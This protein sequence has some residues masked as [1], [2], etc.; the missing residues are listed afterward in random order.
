MDLCW[1][2]SQLLYF[3]WGSLLH[4]SVSLSTIRALVFPRLFCEMLSVPGPEVAICW[5]YFELLCLLFISI[6]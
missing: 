6:P 2:K 1:T 5:S 3:N 4:L